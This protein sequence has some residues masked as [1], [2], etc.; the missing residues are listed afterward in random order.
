MLMF[1]SGDF[2]IIS[3]WFGNYSIGTNQKVEQIYLTLTGAQ[4][5]TSHYNHVDVFI[6][7]L[8]SKKE[9]RLSRDSSERNQNFTQE[10]IGE[11]YFLVTLSLEIANEEYK[12]G[13]FWV[14]I[15][16][17][18]PIGISANQMAIK[19]QL[20]SLPPVLTQLEKKQP[21]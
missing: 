12:V 14:K 21:Q 4:G 10:E 8:E 3:D 16:Q 15:G 18:L 19:Y 20:D 6:L 2:S 11:P 5:L 7:Q 13:T 1:F 17:P 9:W